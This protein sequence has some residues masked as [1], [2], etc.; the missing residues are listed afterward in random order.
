MSLVAKA[1]G[2]VQVMCLTP[3]SPWGWEIGMD[4]LL[5]ARVGS[6]SG[7]Q[8]TPRSW[9]ET[10]GEI[11]SHTRREQGAGEGKDIRGCERLSML[12]V[13]RL[14]KPGRL[15][16]PRNLASPFLAMLREGYACP[17]RTMAFT[18]Q[19]QRFPHLEQH[20][21]YQECKSTFFSF[22]LFVSQ[23]FVTVTK[24]LTSKT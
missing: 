20:F 16:S 22:P 12:R 7:F 24:Y 6:K 11:K 13:L 9:H 8:P 14:H 5:L 10:G 17:W 2:L 4:R 15:P 23:H 3:A 19:A 21:P 1:T 18:N